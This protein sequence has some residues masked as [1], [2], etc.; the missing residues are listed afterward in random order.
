MKEVSDVSDDE[1][2]KFHSFS[3][4]YNGRSADYET[5]SNF[6]TVQEMLKR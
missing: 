5:H 2:N 4:V 1:N 6:A 3:A